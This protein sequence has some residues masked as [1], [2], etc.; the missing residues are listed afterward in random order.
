MENNVTFDLHEAAQFLRMSPEVLRRKAKSG[1]IPAAKPGKRWV[2]LRDDL[3]DY[4]HSLQN[5][6]GQVPRSDW[7]EDYLCH[8]ENAAKRGGSILQR[9]MGS[10]Y[11]NL[12]GLETRPKHRN[13][14]TGSRR[15]TGGNAN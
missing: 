9:P 4:V 7:K 12:L 3:V 6:Y 8:L 13:I 1:K 14:T 2:F 5:S 15:N 10:E 11:A